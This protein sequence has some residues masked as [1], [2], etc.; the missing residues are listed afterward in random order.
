M[1]VWKHQAGLS[2]S[3]PVHLRPPPPPVL[4]E[5]ALCQPLCPRDEGAVTDKPWEQ[6]KWRKRKRD[7]KEEEEELQDEDGSEQAEEE[8]E[9][10][11]RDAMFSEII[12]RIS[13]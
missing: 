13:N 1:D 10:C 7:Y 9:K 2:A 4:F 11:K 3:R 6:K 5:S 12:E 8:E